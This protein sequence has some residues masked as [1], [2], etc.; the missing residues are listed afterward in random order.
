MFVLASVTLLVYLSLNAQASD[1]NKILGGIKPISEGISPLYIHAL[2]RGSGFENVLT[3]TEHL[4]YTG[5]ELFPKLTDFAGSVYMM[6]DRFNDH[7]TIEQN[8]LDEMN[9]INLCLNAHKT[10]KY[11]QDLVPKIENEMTKK[12]VKIYF[13]QID[14]YQ[15][16]LKRFVEMPDDYHKNLLTKT[17]NNTNGLDNVLTVLHIEIV[18]KDGNNGTLNQLLD[19]VVSLKHK[20]LKQGV[21][22][23]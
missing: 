13:Q 18:N 1:N 10:S 9:K 12:K 21:F 16:M 8:I 17:C 22:L 23:N 19:E 7:P 2:D 11:Y 14:E 4:A 6:N 15:D 3:W 5:I 20:C